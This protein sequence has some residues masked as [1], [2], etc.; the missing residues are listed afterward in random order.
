MLRHRDFSEDR[1]QDQ[2]K[3][4]IK[5]S[6]EIHQLQF[7][8]LTGT[9]KWN[10]AARQHDSARGRDHADH[11]RNWAASRAEQLALVQNVSGLW[12]VQISQ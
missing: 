6:R 1:D 4:G 10:L 3:A 7:L 5:L 12:G 11:K 2:V 9:K 8:E